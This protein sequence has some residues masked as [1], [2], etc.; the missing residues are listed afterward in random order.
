M[1]TM[2]QIIIKSRLSEHGAVPLSLDEGWPY[3][4]G[5]LADWQVWVGG[6]GLIVSS[7]LWYAAVSR[8]PLSVAFPFAALSYPLIFASSIVFLH[9]R[10]SWQALAGN[11]LIVLGVMLAASRLP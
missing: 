8:I 6:A 11:G 2:A 4:L 3:V 1:L 9:E 5:L 7:V 10:F